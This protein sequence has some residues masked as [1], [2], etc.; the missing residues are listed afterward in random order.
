[1]ARRCEICGKGPTV[2]INLSHAHKR[3][4]RWVYPNLKRIRINTEGEKGTKRILACTTC[5]KS[6][7]IKK[8][9]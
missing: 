1:M 6:A 3:N 4:K 5:I 9:I 2:G 8:A 7:N